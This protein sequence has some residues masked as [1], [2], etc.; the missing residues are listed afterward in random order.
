[1]KRH[2]Q[3][4]YLLGLISLVLNAVP[5]ALADEAPPVTPPSKLDIKGLTWITYEKINGKEKETAYHYQLIK[6]GIYTSA[7]K[8][9]GVR[10]LRKWDERHP[11][12]ANVRDW[13]NAVVPIGA[14]LAYL[15]K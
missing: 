2:K 14:V 7:T 13:I 12:I 6:G 11:H 10:D 9:K 1:M 15:S 5:P 4:I 3:S 8:I